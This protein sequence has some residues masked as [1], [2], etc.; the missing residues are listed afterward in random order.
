MRLDQGGTEMWWQKVVGPG[1]GSNAECE[2]E[3]VNLGQNVI[4]RRTWNK[5]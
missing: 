2:L 1:V 3:R 5:V 4:V